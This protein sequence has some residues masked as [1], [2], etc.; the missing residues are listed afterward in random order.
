MR[1]TLEK[2]YEAMLVKLSVQNLKQLPMEGPGSDSISL[3]FNTHNYI[4]CK[5]RMSDS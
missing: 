2:S 4:H 1:E 3:L 5:Y